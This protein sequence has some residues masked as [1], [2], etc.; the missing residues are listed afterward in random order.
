MTTLVYAIGNPY[1]RD[2]GVGRRVATLLGAGGW[3][4]RTP[5]ELLPEMAEEVSAAARVIFIDADYVPGESRLESLKPTCCPGLLT[6]GL[7]PCDLLSLTRKLYGF[8]GEAWL[9]R[10]PGEDFGEGEGLSAKAEANALKA[11]A[12]LRVMLDG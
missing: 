4:L 10:V 7:R 5:R 11:A 9:C 2:D 8:A 6:H 1:R 12:L 3:D